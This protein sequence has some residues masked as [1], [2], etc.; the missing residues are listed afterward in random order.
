L[1]ISSYL[2]INLIFTGV[3]A[4]VI[5]YSLVFSPD[6]DNHPVKS[7]SAWFTEK[8]TIST[9]LS[10]SF[11]AIVRLELKKARH[12]NPYGLRIFSFFIIQLLLRV[13]TSFYLQYAGPS[14]RKFLPIVDAC[15]SAILFAGFFLPFLRE[16]LLQ[17]F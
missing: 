12:Y 4:S 8:D 15:V 14:R 9:G 6:K 16:V 3:I 7:G 10:R 2:L 5:I 17:L 1:K 13:G 11:S